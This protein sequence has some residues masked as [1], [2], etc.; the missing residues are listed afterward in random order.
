MRSHIDDQPQHS[1]LV[2]LPVMTLLAGVSRRTMF[3]LIAQ[4]VIPRICIGHRTHLYDPED[5]ITSLKQHFG[6]GYPAAE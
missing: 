6:E 3:R 4:G 5:V 1:R 2:T